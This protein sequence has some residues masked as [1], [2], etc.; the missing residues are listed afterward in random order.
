MIFSPECRNGF[1]DER[2]NAIDGCFCAYDRF[3][4]FS[5]NAYTCYLRS[6]NVIRVSASD[7]MGTLVMILS[8]F[9]DE[10]AFT[11]RQ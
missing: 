4:K 11:S 9:A 3:S 10:S 2:I 6:E 7:Q 5:N 1:D 8:A